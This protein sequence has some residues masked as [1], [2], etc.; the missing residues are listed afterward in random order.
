MILLLR[1]VFIA[2][3]ALFSLVYF[4]GFSMLA[5]IIA[6]VVSVAVSLVLIII[7]EYMSHSFPTRTLVAAILGLMTGL[8]LGHLIV[9]GITRLPVAMVA[10]NMPLISALVYYLT[11][12]G[13]MMFTIIKGEEIAIIDKIV[14]K[15]DEDENDKSASY[16]ILDTSVIIDGRIADICDTGFIEGI[17]VIPNFVLNELQ[18]IADSADSIKRNRGRRGLDI[19]NKMQKDQSIMVKISDM[20]FADIN[21]VDAKLVKLAKIM[22]RQGHH[23]R[24]QPEQGRRVPRGA[25]PQHQP[26]LQRAEARGPARR[27]DAGRPH[28]GG[29]GPEPGDR[30]PGRRHHGGG[31]KRPAAA[32]RGGRR[33]R[34]LGAADDGGTDDIYP[35]QG[36]LRERHSRFS[37][38]PGGKE[39]RPGFT[40]RSWRNWAGWS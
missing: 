4:L 3:N 19:L 13:M 18:M 15:H 24:F 9:L 11:G 39:T 38:A 34:H 7:I 17:L 25:G 10:V 26:A 31:G 6:C 14:P 21:E 35:A 27:G 8:T 22:K 28:Q 33:D 30:L 12:F 36:R 32:Q 1:I 29:E 37:A 2:V 16:K 23:Q 20:D 5:G 40:R